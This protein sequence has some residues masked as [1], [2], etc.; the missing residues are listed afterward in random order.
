M[1]SGTSDRRVTSYT[2]CTLEAKINI[3]LFGE[4]LFSLSEDDCTLF[5]E[6]PLF[7]PTSSPTPT[8]YCHRGNLEREEEVKEENIFIVRVV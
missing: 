2:T 5:S 8:L 6:S 4:Y 7:I 1:S 3:V